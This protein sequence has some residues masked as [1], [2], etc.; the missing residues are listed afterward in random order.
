MTDNHDAPDRV[1]PAGFGAV[2]SASVGLRVERETT[3]G[4]VV[5]RATGDLD[6][7]T[8]PVLDEQLRAAEAIVVPPAHIVLDLT[9]VRF[10][11]SSGL[12]LL[13]QSHQRCE[14]L[15]S[16]LRVVADNRAVLRPIELTGLHRLLLLVPSARQA[17][18][19]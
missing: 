16:S 1:G 2:V 12:A 15:G 18:E 11:S 8:A 19:P 13:V 3:D 9:G 6:I 10:M 5:V 17:L 14:E 4:V 7:A